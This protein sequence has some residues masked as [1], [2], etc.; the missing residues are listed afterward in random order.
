MRMWK[1]RGGNNDEGGMRMGGGRGQGNDEGRGGMT[2]TT[3]HTTSPQPHEQL[4]VGW[5][6]GGMTMMPMTAP[7]TTA[8]S[9]CSWGGR[10]VLMRYGCVR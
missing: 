7:W 9:H 8:M 5:A 1:Q 6:M 4:L 3:E 10:G 2:T